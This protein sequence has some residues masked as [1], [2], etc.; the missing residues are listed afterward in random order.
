[1]IIGED[2]IKNPCLQY[3]YSYGQLL[4]CYFGDNLTIE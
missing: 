2:S 4:H 1:M 3:Y